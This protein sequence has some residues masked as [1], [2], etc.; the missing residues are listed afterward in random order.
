MWSSFNPTFSY[1][2]TGTKTKLDTCTMKVQ[3]V[4][5]VVT[6]SIHSYAV[7]IVDGLCI[8]G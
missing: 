3:N 5:L 6:C 2:L 8:D 7:T 1:Y 4:Y